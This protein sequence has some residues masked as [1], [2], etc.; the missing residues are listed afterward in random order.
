VKTTEKHTVVIA[1][2]RGFERKDEEGWQSH[3]GDYFGVALPAI[4]KEKHASF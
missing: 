3:P 4:M 1:V 2:S